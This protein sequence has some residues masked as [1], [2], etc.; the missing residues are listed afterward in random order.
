VNF[1]LDAVEWGI[2]GDRFYGET[3]VLLQLNQTSARE[4]RGLLVQ[5]GN[6]LVGAAQAVFQQRDLRTSRR[7]SDAAARGIGV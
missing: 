4:R 1:Q 2:G 7:T 6:H 3:F 5:P